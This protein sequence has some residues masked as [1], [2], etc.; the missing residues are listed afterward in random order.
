MDRKQLEAKIAASAA[1]IKKIDKRLKG[2]GPIESVGPTTAR[3]R[4]IESLRQDLKQLDALPAQVAATP[5]RKRTVSESLDLIDPA[6]ITSED[7]RRALHYMKLLNRPH[8]TLA[9][10]LA[11]SSGAQS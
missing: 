7:D 1:I 2:M 4:I 5:A 9:S 8:R 11:Q 6:T 10:V 3:S